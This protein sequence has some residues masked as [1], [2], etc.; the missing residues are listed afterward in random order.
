ML[1]PSCGWPNQA[2]IRGHWP[3]KTIAVKCGHVHGGSW[4]VKDASRLGPFLALPCA[5]IQPPRTC[6]PE[7]T[8]VALDN[9]GAALLGSLPPDSALPFDGSAFD[10]FARFSGGV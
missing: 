6:P 7:H 4:A 10:A 9:I 3:F 8:R 1:R 2:P 5:T